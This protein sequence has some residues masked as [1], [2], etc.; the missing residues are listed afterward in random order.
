MRFPHATLLL[1]AACLAS[2]SCTRA[3]S[4]PI[5]AIVPSP[6]P[7]RGE[8]T[9]VMVSSFASANSMEQ[10]LS[11]AH[12]ATPLLTQEL[13]RTERFTVI[14]QA[15]TGG[16][17]NI[18]ND[19]EALVRA[20]HARVR[21]VIVGMVT[22]TG[23]VSS[24]GNA[25]LYLLGPFRL[26]MPALAS[27]AMHVT[28]SARVIDVW[29]GTVIAVAEADGAS[30]AGRTASVIGVG[31]GGGGVGGAQTSAAPSIAVS[32]ATSAAAAALADSLVAR[33]ARLR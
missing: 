27:R 18:A 1:P 24:N 16:Y 29:S 7:Y 4:A 14:D 32:R 6:E 2:L 26:L 11:A 22:G 15:I 12:I 28:L 30:S 5:A 23:L 3:A 20:R 8:R 25:L 17:A 21:Y 9:A 19:S 31:I 13:V 10:G 33:T